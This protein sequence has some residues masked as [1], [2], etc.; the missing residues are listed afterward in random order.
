MK[1]VRQKTLPILNTS[2]NESSLSYWA[3]KLIKPFV[4]GNGL[5][6]GSDAEAWFEEFEK[7]EDEGA[8]FFC[9]TP[10]ITEAHKVS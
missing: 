9:L 8:Y 1:L 6:D 4:A 3:A 10:I 5:V 2:Y 7:L